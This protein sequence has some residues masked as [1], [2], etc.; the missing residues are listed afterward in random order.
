MYILVVIESTVDVYITN[1]TNIL[2]LTYYFTNILF[3]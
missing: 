1:I 3:Y 2:V